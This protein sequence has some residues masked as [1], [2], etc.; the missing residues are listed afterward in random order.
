ML[1]CGLHLHAVVQFI[2]QIL[3]TFD[4]KCYF[5]V[6]LFVFRYFL[7]IHVANYTSVFLMLMLYNYIHVIN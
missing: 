4:D 2:I 7:K 1:F 5:S 3:Q 6:L